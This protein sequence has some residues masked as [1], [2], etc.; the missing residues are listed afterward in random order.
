MRY[1]SLILFLCILSFP[2]LVLSQL[3]D[4]EL[5][6]RD[7][8]EDDSYFSWHTDN[9]EIIVAGKTKSG[10][11]S[12][13]RVKKLDAFGQ[14]IYSVD[15]FQGLVVPPTDFISMVLGENDD[16]YIAGDFWDCDFSNAAKLYKINLSDGS[17]DWYYD[18]SNTYT[19][20]PIFQD[21][22]NGV[23]FGEGNSLYHLDQNAA[24]IDTITLVSYSPV[25]EFY[26]DHNDG[27]LLCRTEDAIFFRKDESS[28]WNTESSS[29]PGNLKFFE[30][31]FIEIKA[32]SINKY[33]SLALLISSYN[34]TIDSLWSENY[35]HLIDIDETNEKVYYL[36]DRSSIQVLDYNFLPIVSIDLGT[37][38]EIYRFRH[39]EDFLTITGKEFTHSFLKN[40][41]VNS[42]SV[43][44]SQ[45][46][47]LLEIIIDS[48]SAT[49]SYGYISN[50][51]KGTKAVIRNNSNETLNYLELN[52]QYHKSCPPNCYSNVRITI[53]DDLNLAP[54]EIDTILMDNMSFSC[55]D[56]YWSSF[57][58][59]AS[60]PNKSMEVDLTNNSACAEFDPVF[61]IADSIDE[62]ENFSFQIF[63]NPS[64]NFLN[65]EIESTARIGIKMYDILGNTIPLSV[66]QNQIGHLSSGTYFIEFTIGKKSMVKPF[67]KL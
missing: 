54:N 56:S 25:Q 53:A 61:P 38:R 41:P 1:R 67:I 47:E 24:I 26:F 59:F 46:V 6:F 29:N 2:N 62:L 19:V 14:E 58:V 18:L 36:K 34:I 16:L 37:T 52:A 9:D 17:L 65:I 3:S 4:L 48:I 31:G 60:R 30:D 43:Q 45:D 66:G 27:G 64:S 42:S 7:D 15:P 63:P 28:I 33:D 32:N 5:T 35:V 50:S 11:L 39:N 44:Y 51:L 20:T 13:L 23:W 57:C 10:F 55:Q 21:S 49:S 40:I 8:Y 22:D 12:G